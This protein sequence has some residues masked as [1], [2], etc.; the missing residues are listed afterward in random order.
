LAE[1]RHVLVPQRR[2]LPDQQHSQA[3]KHRPADK[4]RQSAIADSPT[5]PPSS[6]G[7]SP[8][9][10]AEGQTEHA[11]VFVAEFPASQPTPW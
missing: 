1:I 6:D 8:T 9:D 2:H 4:P 11:E 5:S 3:D 10:H 7:S